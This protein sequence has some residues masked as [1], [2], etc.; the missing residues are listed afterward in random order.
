MSGKPSKRAAPGRRRPNFPALAIFSRTPVP[1][2]AKTRLIPLLGPRG[3]AELHAALSSD[4]INKVENLPLNVTRYL[5][6]AGRRPQQLPNRFILDRQRGVGLGVRLQN[7]FQTLLRY[8]ASAVVIGTD[9]PLLP[10]AIIRVAF[11]ELKACD[12][13]LGPCPDGGYYLIG[14]R[15]SS[16]G[17]FRGVRWGTAFAFRDTLDKL[18]RRG[19]SCSILESHPDV[20]VPAD[21]RLLLREL[22][23]SPSARRLAPSTWKCLT[24]LI[25]RGKKSVGG[26][27][28]RAQK[29]K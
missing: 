21:V 2:R 15:R 8:H 17:L 10:S 3:A 1:G 4:T 25:D 9:S 27:G 28:R 11:T 12:A 7:A 5:F 22:E 29:L 14:L 26:R 19:Y 20:D 24:A 23:R 13:V 6:L 18:L 16:P